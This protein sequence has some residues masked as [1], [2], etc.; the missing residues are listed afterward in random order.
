MK[1]PINAKEETVGIASIGSY[2]PSGVMTS[3][4]ISNSANLPLPVLTD[5]IGMRQKHIA[6]KN[7][8]PSE[9]GCKAALSAIEKAGISPE[10]VDIIAYC[11][12][13]HYD[14]RFWSPAAKI[15]AQLRAH[16]AFAFEIKN[17]CNSGNLGIH[18]CRNLLLHDPE[19]TNALVI[20]SDTLSRLVDHADNS[21][22]SLLMF[23]DG[24]VAAILK[25]AEKTNRILSY[26]AMTNGSLADELKIPLGGTKVPA[27]EHYDNNKERL[28]Y[29]KVEDNKRL[30][31]IL[32]KFYL[33]NYIS[34]IK[35]SIYKSGYSIKDV[36]FLFTNQVKKSLFENILGTLNLNSENTFISLAE[37]GHMGAV[38]TL[39][40]LSKILEARRIQANDIV[41]LASSAAGFSWA[42]LT[43]KFD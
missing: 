13:G 32:A 4:I 36:D 5:K 43:I 34:V 27:A 39:F 15:Q 19:L 40:C 8:H 9:M 42:A 1:S 38:D 31:H 21:S 11:G 3:E 37:Y 2:I 25:K 18:I 35:Q 17:F 10:E 12:A 14:Y 20:C 30:E 22:P 41:V 6:D 23:A 7:E 33:E 16:S 29:V 24:A 28:Q 26:H